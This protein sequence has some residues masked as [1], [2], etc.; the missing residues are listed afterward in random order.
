M[1]Y[2]D[3]ACKWEDL[4]DNDHSIHR[5]NFL[6]ERHSLQILQPVDEN[7]ELKCWNNTLGGR[8]YPKLDY[9]K[10]F[11]DWWHLHH[12][13]ISVP[14]E[15]TQENVRYDAEVTLAHFYEVEHYKNQV[16]NKTC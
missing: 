9:S 14:S 2:R 13:E 4:V 6:I 11:P 15:H 12:T 10:G 7:G 3:G 16:R 1:K 8:V 5:N